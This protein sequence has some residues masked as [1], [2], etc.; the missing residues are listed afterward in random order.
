MMEIK[1]VPTFKD[2]FD[3]LVLPEWLNEKEASFVFLQND[4]GDKNHLMETCRCFQSL[5]D[6]PTVFEWDG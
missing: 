6:N 5:Y 4:K 1:S 2:I 3:E